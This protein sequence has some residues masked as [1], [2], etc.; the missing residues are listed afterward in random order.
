ME[1]PAN[2]PRVR[3]NPPWLVGMANLVLNGNG[4]IAAIPFLLRR[5]GLAV[6]EIASITAVLLI[7]SF[8]FFLWTPI[9]ELGLSRRHW[10]MLLYTVAAALQFL[11]L[12]QP[13]P[14]HLVW[15]AVL[16]FAANLALFAPLGILGPLVRDTVPVPLRGQASGWISATGL[17]SA[18]GAGL[19]IWIAEH[20]SRTAL[21]ASVA[22]LGLIPVVVM[23]FAYEPPR[24]MSARLKEQLRTIVCDIRS[25]FGARSVRE[26]LVVFMSPMAAVAMTYLFSGVAVDYH[27]TGQTTAFLGGIGWSIAGAAGSL[28]GGMLVGRVGPLRA[29]PLAGVL[30][31]ICGG[32]MMLGSFS[33]LTFAIG[34]TLY[35][36]IAGL[37]G[38]GFVALAIELTAGT[39]NAASTWFATLWATANLPW[40][41]MQWADGRGYQHFGP[42]GMLAVDA[43]GNAAPALLFLVYLKRSR[44]APEGP[45]A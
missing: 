24:V 40:A 16:L 12:L 8:S 41:Y 27:V 31:G 32:G 38:A 43:L 34:S 36:G 11:A 15:F 39:G 44:A 9:V 35:L 10:W 33:P 17:I 28:A 26:G 3:Y 30:A 2:E 19:V 29:Y 18:S 7:P 45:A 20:W 5:A 37:C 25:G 23:W 1:T 13:L 4:F 21:A 14:A 22:A 42:R 6:P